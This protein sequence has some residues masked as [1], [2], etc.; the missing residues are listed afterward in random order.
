[1]TEYAN[2]IHF[3]NLFAKILNNLDFIRVL[4]ASSVRGATSHVLPSQPLHVWVCVCVCVCVRACVRACVCLDLC[5]HACIH[6]CGEYYYY[7]MK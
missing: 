1:M 6:A 4:S 3:C 2:Y 5:V 7:I